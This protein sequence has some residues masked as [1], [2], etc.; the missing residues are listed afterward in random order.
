MVVPI[1]SYSSES[2]EFHTMIQ[3]MVSSVSSFTGRLDFIPEFNLSL[4]DLIVSHPRHLIYLI[5]MSLG[6]MPRVPTILYLPV[7]HINNITRP[8]AICNDT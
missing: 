8:I 6:V 2:L 4:A 1:E 7:A 5:L 3:Q